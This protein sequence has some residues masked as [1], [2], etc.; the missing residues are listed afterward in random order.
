MVLGPALALLPE[1]VRKLA[2]LLD[3]ACGA[4]LGSSPIAVL[5]ALSTRECSWGTQA[6]N[7]QDRPYISAL[8]KHGAHESVHQEL[9]MRE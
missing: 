9:G 6:F 1:S 7:S 2:T 3:A 5:T 8:M 4:H